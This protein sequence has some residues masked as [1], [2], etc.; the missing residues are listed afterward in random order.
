MIPCSCA[1]VGAETVVAEERV[2]LREIVGYAAVTATETVPLTADKGA[3]VSEV[4]VETGDRVA[5]GDTLL[6]VYRNGDRAPL[7]AAADGVVADIASPGASSDGKRPVCTL[8]DISRLSIALLL[9]EGDVVSVNAGD[10]A[11]VTALSSGQ[12]YT[13]VVIKTSAMPESDNGR[14][15]VRLE[16]DNADGR[17]LPGMTVKTTLSVRREG[18]LLPHTAVGYDDGGYYACSSTGEKL[19]L[20]DAAYCQEGYLVTGIEPGRV[21]VRYVERVGS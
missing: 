3:V 16:L 13:A 12:R 20:L 14:Y 6:T 17:L 2:G 7:A 5:K 10:E 19:R 4:F 9:T 8:M 21:V 18:V 15:R 1:C 11:T